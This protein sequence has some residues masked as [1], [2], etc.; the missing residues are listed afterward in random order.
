MQLYEVGTMKPRINPTLHLER[1]MMQSIGS[2]N[3]KPR[4]D[5]TL[6]LERFHV[7]L[8]EVGT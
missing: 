5:Q 3:M 4:I 8:Y 1:F 6:H 7:Q 2:W